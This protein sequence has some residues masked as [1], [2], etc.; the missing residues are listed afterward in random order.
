[1]KRLG[2]FILLLIALG[3]PVRAQKMDLTPL[4]LK[5]IASHVVV[6]TVQ[7]IYERKEVS[8]DWVTTRYVA[9]VRVR[10]VEKGG[11]IAQD[12]LLYIRYWRQTWVARHSGRGTEGHRGL[13]AEGA[14]LRIYLSR[15]TYDG[16]G[17][18]LDGGFNVIGGNGFEKLPV[19]QS[20]EQ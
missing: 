11:G 8:R 2:C 9:E 15:Y 3:E 1:M 16:F 6:G 7:R 17:P 5:A 4:Q 14:T 10:A 19:E 18:N 12:G 13:P 20:R